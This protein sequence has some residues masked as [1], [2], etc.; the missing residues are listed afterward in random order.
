MCYNSLII[1]T[2]VIYYHGYYS[3]YPLLMDLRSCLLFYLLDVKSFCTAKALN[4]VISGRPDSSRGALKIRLA[5][6][7]IL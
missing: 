4:L 7:N 3:Y 2:C 6:G 1:V 5:F